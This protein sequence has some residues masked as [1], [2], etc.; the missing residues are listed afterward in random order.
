[1]FEVYVEISVAEA[2]VSINYK[3]EISEAGS[4]ESIGTIV[5]MKKISSK[6]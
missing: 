4:C 2:I 3:F 5:S 1:M 6:L